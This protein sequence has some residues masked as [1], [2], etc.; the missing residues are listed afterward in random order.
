MAVLSTVTAVRTGV[1]V[2]GVAATAG[3]DTFTNTGAETLHVFNGDASPI[4]VTLTTT[5]TVDGLAVADRAVTVAAGARLAIGPFKRLEYGA[6]VSVA[7]SAV[8][9]V[10]VAV[11]KTTPETV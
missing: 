7:Y 5:A 1:S 3:G 8:T 2:A 10:T 4:T 11:L 9:S 6:T